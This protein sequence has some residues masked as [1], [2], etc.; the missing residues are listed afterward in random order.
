ME[1]VQHLRTDTIFNAIRGARRIGKIERF[2][3]KASRR[4]HYER[5]VGLPHGLVTMGDA[6]C[7]FNPVYGQG[8][9]C[10]AKQAV[11][12][13][14]LLEEVQR[15]GCTLDEVPNRF[16]PRAAELVE[17]P[18]SM[19]AIPDFVYPGTQGVAP[20]GIQMMIA[21]SAA[22]WEL[23]A[24]D[25]AVHKLVVEVNHLLRPRSAIQED[26]E[27]MT[28]VFEMMGRMQVAHAS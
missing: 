23:A 16:R 12:L 3:M 5:L 24:E 14:E 19:A 18:W 26:P 6:I 8:M 15:G 4:V 9:T 11:C 20:E 1:F 28:R 13:K 7:R 2:R 25:P 22:L 10:A 21:F 17:T 27:L